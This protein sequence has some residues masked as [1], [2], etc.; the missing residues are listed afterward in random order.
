[1][2]VLNIDYTSKD[3]DGFRSGMLNHA[4]T[5][6]PDWTGRDD[7]A[8]FGVM[9]IE[10]FAYMGDI[11]SFYQDRVQAESFLQTATRRSSVLAHAELLGYV[12]IGRVAATGTVSLTNGTGGNIDV[13][14][15]TVLMTEHVDALDS[16][17]FFTTVN[18]VTVNANSTLANVDVVEGFPEGD[19]T[20]SYAGD[21]YKVELMGTSD[22]T[23]DQRFTLKNSG[24]IDN[25]IAVFGDEFN[26]QTS[27]TI[28]PFTRYSFILNAGPSDYG[29]QVRYDD[30]NRANVVFGDGSSGAIPPNGTRLY[31]AYRTGFGKSGNVSA[32]N[33]VVDTY[34]YIAGITVTAS[35]AMSGG[36]D[37]ETI[38]QIRVNAPR[39]WQ[40]QNR[41][42]T[43]TDFADLSL[44]LGSVS[45]A[46]AYAATSASV[47]VYVLG[48]GSA[49]MS[50]ADLDA[51]QAYLQ[52]RAMAGQSVTVQNGVQIGVNLGTSGSNVIIGVADRYLR[53]QVKDA[54]TQALNDF[55]SVAN[56]DFAM[57]VS[58]ANVYRAIA[59]VPGVTYAV[60]PVMA[61]A[62]ATQSGTN[63]ITFQAWEIPKA[64]TFYLTAEGG[65]A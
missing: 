29:F 52:E 8:D 45:K 19:T 64:G 22:G 39:V 63:D 13:P 27:E 7:A 54:V 30:R 51:V 6:F 57:R 18:D 16:P 20:I 59:E 5:N 65:I 28:L 14:A 61:R 36:A 60:I 2:G 48:S 10:A 12:P 58:L 32:V 34:A 53:T 62:D 3:F 55:F 1:M 9:L 33:A 35:S 37:E 50:Q 24:V 38:E 43:L 25:S 4:A 23:S 17:V 44:A 49:T 56:T 40:T 11:L 21:T 15:G 46:N 31:A 26:P 42:V 41:A 47:I